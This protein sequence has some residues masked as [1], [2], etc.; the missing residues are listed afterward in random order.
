MAAIL[1]A[2]LYNNVVPLLS[3]LQHA[4]LKTTNLAGYFDIKKPLFT[5]TDRYM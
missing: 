4:F 3:Q 5:D 2:I 1:V